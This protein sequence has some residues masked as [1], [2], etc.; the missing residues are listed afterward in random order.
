MWSRIVYT[1]TAMLPGEFIVGAFAQ[2][3]EWHQEDAI[4]Q[5]SD[6]DSDNLTKNLVTVLA[7]VRGIATVTLPAGIVYGDLE[8]LS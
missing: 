5:V 8:A 6:S 4:I 2:A 1:T 3:C 7:E